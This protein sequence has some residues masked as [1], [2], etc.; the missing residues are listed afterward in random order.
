MESNRYNNQLD[1]RFNQEPSGHQPFNN[2]NPS[3]RRNKQSS[4]ALAWGFGGLVVGFILGLLALMLVSVFSELDLRSSSQHNRSLPQNLDYDSVEVIYDEVRAKYDGPLSEEQLIIG[5][6]KGLVQATGDPH[7]VY[8]STEESQQLY[9]DLEGELV[10]VGIYID[11]RGD[12]IVVVSPIQGSPA[13]KAGLKSGDILSKVDDRDVRGLDAQQVS[14]LVRGE[15]GTKVVIGVQRQQK[16]GSWEELSFTITRAKLDVPS[17]IYEV[18]DGIGILE[19]KQFNLNTAKGKA[20]T[21]E[22]MR[23]ATDL[24]RQE[25]I[26][27][28][29]LDLRLNPGGDLETTRMVASFWLKDAQT[30]F[31]LGNYKKEISVPHKSGESGLEKEYRGSLADIPLVILVD[32][33]SA[34][35]SEVLMMALIDN[36]LGRVLGSKTYGKTTVQALFELDNGEILRLTTQHW[37]S[38][39]GR[40]VT[41]GYSPSIMVADD[42][43]TE[44][45]D[46]VLERA[47]ELLDKED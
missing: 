3:P 4:S 33:G 38:P 2:Y 45:V 5:L 9:A 25:K 40:A 30:I 15:E 10:G 43:Q 18:Q 34:S 42:P 13:D 28:L 6:K 24:F 32:Q 21:T 23:E 16:E 35:A 12:D 41:N 11:R 17:V 39:T 27:G 29:V 7:S 36:G 14:S 47:L 8:Y 26:K 44:D 46:E 22:G 31:Q 20:N 1:N 19:I 37:Y